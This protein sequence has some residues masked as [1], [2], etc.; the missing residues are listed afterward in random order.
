MWHKSM[1]RERFYGTTDG[2]EPSPQVHEV[3]AKLE[4]CTSDKDF[5][6]REGALHAMDM[7]WKYICK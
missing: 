4:T 2:L 7:A 6:M 1:H 3:L 5:L